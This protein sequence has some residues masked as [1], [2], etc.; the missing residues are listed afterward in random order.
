MDEDIKN[1]KVGRGAVLACQQHFPS[2][3]KEASS[4]CVHNFLSQLPYFVFDLTVATMLFL[5]KNWIDMP[6]GI[7]QIP[8]YSHLLHFIALA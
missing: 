1:K 3:F 4:I 7:R 5:A 2:P 6:F 8:K